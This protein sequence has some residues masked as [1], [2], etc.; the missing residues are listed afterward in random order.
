MK[1]VVVTDSNVE[2]V[3]FEFCGLSVVSSVIYIRF[4]VF[5]PDHGYAKRWFDAEIATKDLNFDDADQWYSGSKRDIRD[6]SSSP[7][8][9]KIT[10]GVLERSGLLEI[11]YEATKRFDSSYG[12]Y[13]GNLRIKSFDLKLV[14]G[15]RIEEVVKE[16]GDSICVQI[17]ETW[18]GRANKIQTDES[19]RTYFWKDRR[20]TDGS[21][22]SL[23]KLPT[24]G[25]IEK[26][27]KQKQKAKM[28]SIR[29][30]L[31]NRTRAATV[32]RRLS[33]VPDGEF[34]SNH[35]FR[36]P[37]TYTSDVDIVDIGV[38][39]QRYEPAR[40][41]IFTLN[42]Q[43]L[44]DQAEKNKRQSEHDLSKLSHK[45]SGTFRFARKS[46]K[47][48][49]ISMQLSPRKKSPRKPIVPKLPINI[50][51]NPLTKSRQIAV[52]VNTLIRYKVNEKGAIVITDFE[53][54]ADLLRDSLYLYPI[55]H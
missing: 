2:I 46:Q 51:N 5:F 16:G 25:E 47:K 42:L 32:E 37:L 8:I 30:I 39:N 1:S 18:L 9:S 28:A 35:Q 45:S 29:K 52:G 55:I 23:G 40:F 31:S 6:P 54:E 27:K 43:E 36:L 24:F 10:T 12:D 26:E 48:K 41:V 4:K 53:L 22:D 44:R 49:R 50:Q 15:R 11:V 38:Y 33:F 19:L 34:Y 20:K 3:P 14:G 17:G 7:R 21:G 13:L